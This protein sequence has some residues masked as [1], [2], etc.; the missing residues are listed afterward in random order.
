METTPGASREAE[1]PSST[2]QQAKKANHPGILR[3]PSMSLDTSEHN[4]GYTSSEIGQEHP[5]RSGSPSSTVH[6]NKEAEFSGRANT[7]VIERSAAENDH[8]PQSKAAKIQCTLVR[9]PS[10]AP[11]PA[12]LSRYE[13]EVGI[14][15]G[16]ATVLN[17]I[18]KH[19]VS[20]FPAKANQDREVLFDEIIKTCRRL[21]FGVVKNDVI[22]YL[23]PQLADPATSIHMPPTCD[24][25]DADEIF[26]AIQTIKGNTD[27]SFIHKAYSQ[28][29]LYHAV[30]AK[31]KTLSHEISKTLKAPKTVAIERMAKD[32]AG[33]QRGKAQGKSKS[34]Y[35]HAYSAGRKWL[36]VV[37]W[38]GGPGIIIVFVL[39]GRQTKIPN[40]IYMCLHLL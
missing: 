31:S 2:A 30:E 33:D 19:C 37:Q 4:T 9:I 3:A 16:D 13:I 10:P 39:A 24:L 1:W 21:D 35:D 6:Q 14:V 26:A 17:R 7:P 27:H 18:K 8:D 38:F 20:N 40:L 5:S 36:E 11:T 28:M 12:Q 25:S 22:S 23:E 34:E 29:K 32:Q 15:R